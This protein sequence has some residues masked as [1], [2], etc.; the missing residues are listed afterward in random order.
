M[1]HCPICNTQTSQKYKDSPYWT[2]PYCDCW[3]QNPMP[4]KV[5]E[6]DHEKGENGEF[7]GNLMSD[8]EKGINIELAQRIFQNFMG[9]KPGKTLDVGSKYPFLSYCLKNLGCEAFGLDNIEVVP[10][11]SKELDVPMLMAD[12]E[13]LTE[14]QI[15]EWTH[16]EKFQVITLIHTF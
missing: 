15:R 1:A 14:E 3:F 13:A 6:A 10:E 11:Y 16:T 8:Y 4:P 7:I 12:F 2:C 9:S 5:Y